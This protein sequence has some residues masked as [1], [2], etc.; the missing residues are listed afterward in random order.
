MLT[1]RSGDKHRDK[2]HGARRHR[3]HGEA[4]PGG[5]ADPQH[6]PAGAGRRAGRQASGVVIRVA[7]ADDSP[8]TCNLLASYL[9]AGGDCK[10]VGV[11]HDAPSTL[12]LI[13]DDV[14]GRADARSADAGRRRPRAAARAS[15]RE[16]S[17]SV[18]VIS[19]VTRLRRGDDAA[20]ARARRGRFHPEVHARR[21]G[22]PRLAA[23]RDRRQG[24]DRRRGAP[25]AIAAA[26]RRRAG[27]GRRRRVR[28]ARSAT[29]RPAGRAARHGGVV[30]HRRVDRRAR[31]RSASCSNQLPAGLRP[32]CVVVQHLPATF[33][34]PFAAQLSATRALARRRWPTAGDRA[35][36]GRRAGGAGLAPPR[37]SARRPHPS[38]AAG[39]SATS[40]GRRSIWR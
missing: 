38:A 6:R 35:R 7:I 8:F 16:P 26:A 15:D 11:A 33:T 10:V 30:D 12:D 31:A 18:V 28:V 25:A 39:A 13:R 9:E 20:R 29:A 24:Q 19:G 37:R 14:A 3:L 2:A 1:S 4:V 34:A 21:A 22:E 36:A 17:V 27:A 23:A 40:I 5:R 32:A